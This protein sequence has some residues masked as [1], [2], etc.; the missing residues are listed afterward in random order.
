MWTRVFLRVAGYIRFSLDKQLIGSVDTG[1]GFYA[2]GHF[3]GYN[4][5]INGSLNAPF[6]QEFYFLI[7]LAVGGTNGYF[8]DEGNANGK[9]WRNSSPTAKRDFWT[10]RQQW[11]PGWN[12]NAHSRIT[13]AFRVDYIKVFAL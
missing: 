8:P 4:P 2:R 5:W 1:A 12:F 3:S 6:D 10:G 11:L 7:N 13:S 9:P